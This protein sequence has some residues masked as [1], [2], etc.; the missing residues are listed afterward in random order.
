[1]QEQVELRCQFEVVVAEEAVGEV[2]AWH[3]GEGEAGRFE[4]RAYGH[5]AFDLQ[6]VEVCHDSRQGSFLFSWAISNISDG[7]VND[8]HPLQVSEVD[9]EMGYDPVG[10]R[11]VETEQLH[12]YDRRCDEN[13]CSCD[14]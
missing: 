3:Q 8:G 14:T 13:N 1:M 12:S 9:R 2:E 7:L 6:S 11:D 5:C 4:V 10:R